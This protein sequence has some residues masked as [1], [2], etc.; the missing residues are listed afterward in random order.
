LKWSEWSAATFA[1]WWS[2]TFLAM[3][4][5]ANTA[6]HSLAFPRWWS[7]VFFSVTFADRWASVLMSVPFA[8]RHATSFPIRP[9]PR[10]RATA[11]LTCPHCRWR[12]ATPCA[13]TFWSSASAA[14][15]SIE[16]T[17]PLHLL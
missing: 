8:G 11:L 5:S 16:L 7:A 6:L 4:F 1:R 13:G 2:A 10:G 9:F 14:A 12:T 17:D 3:A 15:I